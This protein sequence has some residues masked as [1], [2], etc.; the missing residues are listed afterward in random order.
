MAA[1]PRYPRLGTHC[2]ITTTLGQQQDPQTGG[3]PERRGE[4]RWVGC[5][6]V[7]DGGDAQRGK[8]FGGLRTDAPERVDAAVTHHRHPVLLGERE[9]ARGFAESGGDLGALLVVADA[10]RTRQPRLGGDDGAD[11]FGQLEGVGHVGT[12]VGLVPAPHLQRVAQVAQQS[13]H[14]F[15]RFV[16]GVRV[17]RQERGV[18]AAARRGAQRHAGM[19]AELP[20]LVRSARDDLAWFGRITAAPDD[21]RQSDEFGVAP[22]F[23]R[24]EELVEVDVQ[25]PRVVG[26]ARHCPHS[27]RANDSHASPCASRLRSRSLTWCA[28]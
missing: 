25:D 2:G 10:H 28:T 15:G 23:D 22:Q 9:D 3:R 5:G 20:R 6:E 4:K 18:R 14:L 1:R 8:P 17:G 11:A 27:L 24:R 19:H 13:H 26:S 16:V 7:G 21:H 12:Q